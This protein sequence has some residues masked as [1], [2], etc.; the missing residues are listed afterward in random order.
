MLQ[1]FLYI[2]KQ[3]INYFSY[4]KIKL[5]TKNIFLWYNIYMHKIIRFNTLDSTSKFIERERMHISS[6]SLVIA[7]QQTSGIG[8]GENSWLSPKGNL[9]GTFYKEYAKTQNELKHL[10]INAA[11]EIADLLV[12]QFSIY[13]LG[14]KWPNDL[15]I[16]GKKIGGILVKTFKEKGLNKSSAIIGVGINVAYAPET[17]QPTT[18]LKEH[19]FNID[20]E[21]L[22]ESLANNFDPFI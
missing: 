18:C 19:G 22:I 3:F 6:N 9:Y 7:Y 14:I 1:H 8:Q 21:E 13:S 17:T 4:E 2:V 12:K 11:V 15:F 5:F 10:S 20:L 16:D